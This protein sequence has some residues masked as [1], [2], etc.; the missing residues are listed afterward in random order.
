MQGQRCEALAQVG[1]AFNISRRRDML[2]GLK[3]N[4]RRPGPQ[5]IGELG[6]D[7]H[8]DHG[9]AEGSSLRVAQALFG[10]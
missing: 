1:A 2:V 3:T 6:E 7:H 10:V 9:P 5:G 4:P 8:H